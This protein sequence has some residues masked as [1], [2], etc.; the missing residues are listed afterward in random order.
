MDFKLRIQRRTHAASAIIQRNQRG[1]FC[2]GGSV[3]L[4]ESVR[5]FNHPESTNSIEGSMAT[6]AKNILPFL[7]RSFDL[8]I[9][10]R[11]ME[12]VQTVDS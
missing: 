6:F 12:A 2:P 5:S 3:E 9:S 11:S 4:S 1:L 7:K 8:F 10:Y